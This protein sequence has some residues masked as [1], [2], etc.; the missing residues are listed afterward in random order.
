MSVS[1]Q[2]RV[3]AGLQH[4]CRSRH[5]FRDSG[6]KVD[7]TTSCRARGSSPSRSSAHGAPSYHEVPV[8]INKVILTRSRRRKGPRHHGGQAVMRAAIST[9]L[10]KG[11]CPTCARAATPHSGRRCSRF[12][13]QNVA[14]ARRTDQP[15]EENSC[16]RVRIR[17][18]SGS[19]NTMVCPPSARD[20]P[21][22]GPVGS[23]TYATR[24]LWRINSDGDAGRQEQ[25][26]FV[27][28]VGR[29]ARNNQDAEDGR[30]RSARA[31]GHPVREDRRNCLLFDPAEA[32]DSTAMASQAALKARFRSTTRRV[33]GCG[34]IAVTPTAAVC[35]FT[36]PPKAVLVSSASSRRS[37]A[38]ARGL[39]PAALPLRPD[40]GDDLRR[41][42]RACAGLKRPVTTASWA[43]RTSR[44][45]CWTAN[46]SGSAARWPGRS[47]C[48][49]GPQS[50]ASTWRSCCA[51]GSGRKTGSAS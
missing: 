45:Q 7:G 28:D 16:A 31:T 26:G 32:L 38:L 33:A 13:L 46:T 2:R 11:R 12:R 47:E 10:V 9:P 17:R 50:R 14:A 42:P 5:S 44:P 4:V 51:S 22:D 18:A 30:P 15:D 19:P 49:P 36:R 20:R 37:G 27:L 23:L 8:P 34:A 40:T 35:W 48:F 25:H 6:A 1:R 21:A 24:T 3:P 43:T 39:R 29:W 41:A